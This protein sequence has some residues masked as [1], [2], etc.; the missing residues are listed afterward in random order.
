MNESVPSHVSEFCLY[1]VIYD[2]GMWLFFDLQ[3]SFS[4][5]DL[6]IAAF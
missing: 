5:V 3:V 1:P 6:L 2:N 4:N